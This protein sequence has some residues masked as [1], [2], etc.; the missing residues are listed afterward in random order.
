MSKKGE[1]YPTA[2]VLTIKKAGAMS[3]QGRAEIARWLRRHANMLVK[4]G[5][6]YNDKGNFV[7]RYYIVPIDDDPYP[8]PKA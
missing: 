8:E 5:D 3:P 2:A 6:Q 1:K 7:G 4:L